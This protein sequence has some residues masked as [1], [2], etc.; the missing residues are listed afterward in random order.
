MRIFIALD[1]DSAIR[2]KI[3]EFMG[4]IRGNAPHVRW[5]TEQSL[6]ITLKFIGEKPDSGVK[7]VEQ[8]LSSIQA[9]QFQLS[10]GTT[11]FFPTAKA[12]RVF[13]IGIDAEPGL[14]HLVQTIEASLATLGI[15][16][17]A[18]EFSPHL[19]L[20]R[21]RGGSGAPAWRKGDTPNRQFAQLQTYLESH[22]ALDFGSMITRDFFLYQS[23]LSSKGARYTKIAQYQLRPL[24]A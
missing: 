6:H 4:K 1:I 7:Q 17:E 3:R 23:H 2:D 12:A 19:T 18:R 8:A 16:K 10:F 13:W 9:E 11:G 15:P 5:V 21:S 20:A 22:P 24:T 14:V